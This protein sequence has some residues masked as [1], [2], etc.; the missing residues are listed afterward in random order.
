MLKSLKDI[1]FVLIL[2]SE[3]N[4]LISLNSYIKPK[5]SDLNL[6]LAEL[7]GPNR[8]NTDGKKWAEI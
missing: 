3:I 6:K 4:Q 8:N 1:V 2:F 5:V 7:R